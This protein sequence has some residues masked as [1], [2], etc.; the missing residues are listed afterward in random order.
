MWQYANVLI[1]TS[2]DENIAL[3]V[4]DVEIG[5]SVHGDFRLGVAFVS[6]ELRRNLLLWAPTARKKGGKRER[7]EGGGGGGEEQQ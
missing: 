5:E 3:D 6:D 2:A 1:T 7:K 4:N